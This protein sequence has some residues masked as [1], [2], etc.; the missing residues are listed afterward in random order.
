MVFKHKKKNFFNPLK[1]TKVPILK[2]FLQSCSCLINCR[3]P[4][5]QMFWKITSYFHLWTPPYFMI[6]DINDIH[7]HFHLK[8]IAI[9]NKLKLKSKVSNLLNNWSNSVI[10]DSDIDFPFENVYDSIQISLSHYSL[11]LQ[12]LVQNICIPL[13]VCTTLT[14]K[15]NN[16]PRLCNFVMKIQIDPFRITFFIYKKLDNS[17][18]FLLL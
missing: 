13:T 8:F 16:S 12:G 14:S 2:V 1:H 6:S 18:N 3:A 4:D 9:L 17:G 7:P 11:I 15:T 5:F 10:F